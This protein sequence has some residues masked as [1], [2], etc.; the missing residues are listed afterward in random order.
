[1]HLVGFI[2]RIYHDARTPECQR[3]LTLRKSLG[4][5]VPYDREKVQGFIALRIAGRRRLA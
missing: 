5:I 3:K 2:I 1:V 4:K